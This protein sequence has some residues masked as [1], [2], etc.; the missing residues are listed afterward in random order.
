[1]PTK[2]LRIEDNN[3]AEREL[4]PV[5]LIRK[6]SNGNASLKGAKVQAVMMTIYRT[7]KLRNHDPLETIAKALKE[8][9]LTG[10]LPALPE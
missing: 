5:V 9:I 2:E 8:Y 1:V 6:N 10:K 3:H 7:L 4:R